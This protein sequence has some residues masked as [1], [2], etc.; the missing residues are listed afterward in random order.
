MP[1]SS[2]C[3]SS[4]RIGCRVR[5]AT[6]ASAACALIAF[7]LGACSGERGGPDGE[8]RTGAAGG[9]ARTESNPVTFYREYVTVEPSRGRT[10]VS[11]LYYFRNTSDRPVQQLISYPFPVD[12]FHLYPR[13]VRVWEKTADGLRPMGFVHRERSVRWSMR[14]GPGE[15]KVVRVDYTQEIRRPHARYIV[16]TTKY[17]ERPIDLAEFEF[18]VPASLDS[19]RLSF[20]P[21]RRSVSGDTVIYYMRREQFMPDDDLNITWRE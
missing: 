2:T 11:A 17:W 6:R 12:R 15:E 13:T 20:D 21:D 14:F 19:V 10:S 1:R 8:E 5:Q 16:T 3:R 18:R 4:G 9:A 7:A